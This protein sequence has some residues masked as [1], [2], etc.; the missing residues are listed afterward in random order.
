MST[1][2]FYIFA[3][4]LRFFS[5]FLRCHGIAG[6]FF[7]FLCVFSL[8]FRQFRCSVWHRRHFLVV[9]MPFSGKPLLPT[10]S[11]RLTNISRTYRFLRS[12]R[13]FLAVCPFF[14]LVGR[15]FSRKKLKKGGFRFVKNKELY[16][17]PLF[18]KE[19]R[20]KNRNNHAKFSSNR[21]GRGAF[22]RR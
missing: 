6:D 13:L 5:S 11:P 15:K 17:K 21:C 4:F 8:L 14:A 12:E 3:P 10:G 18:C 2:A 20:H 9:S 1:F 22:C 16:K 19:R 7:D